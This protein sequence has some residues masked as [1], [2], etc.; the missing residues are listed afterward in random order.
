[1]MI[2]NGPRNSHNYPVSKYNLDQADWHWLSLPIKNENTK[3]TTMATLEV[4]RINYN[5]FWLVESSYIL[6]ENLI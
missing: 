4:T 5:L 2:W 3:K 6:Y 1:M